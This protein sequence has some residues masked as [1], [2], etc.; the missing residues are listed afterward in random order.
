MSPKAARFFQKNMCVPGV[1][2]AQPNQPGPALF[3]NGGLQ[4]SIVQKALMRCPSSFCMSPTPPEP[5][6]RMSRQ[7]QKRGSEPL[8]IESASTREIG[9]QSTYGER[10]TAGCPRPSIQDVTGSRPGSTVP[11]W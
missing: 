10:Y 7:M 11:S 3:S 2:V 4:T 9:L 8:L 5:V 6:S 1:L